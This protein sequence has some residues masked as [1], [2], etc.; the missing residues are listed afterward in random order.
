V[1][2]SGPNAVGTQSSGP[3]AVKSKAAGHHPHDLVPLRR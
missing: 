2:A 3:A 1:S